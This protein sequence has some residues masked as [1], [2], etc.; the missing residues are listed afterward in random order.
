MAIKH[1]FLMAIGGYYLPLK[2]VDVEDDIYLF[3]TLW[4]IDLINIVK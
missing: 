1:P 3:A 2:A 4:A